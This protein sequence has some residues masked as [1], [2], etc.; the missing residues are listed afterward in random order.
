M[1]SLKAPPI[2]PDGIEGAAILE[3]L[4]RVK[5]LESHDSEGG[6]NGADLVDIVTGWF[7][8]LGLDV[9]LPAET[10]RDQLRG[11]PR[12]FTVIGLRDNNAGEVLV[13][14]VVRGAVTPVDKTSSSGGPRLVSVGVRTVDADQAEALALDRLAGQLPTD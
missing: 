14:G 8:E 11:G 3:L 6:W 2:D 10:V 9:T 4:T 12:V 13:A 1:T 5:G 7:E